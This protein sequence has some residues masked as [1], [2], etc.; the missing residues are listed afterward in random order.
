M[1]GIGG[2]CNNFSIKA[3]GIYR[4]TDGGLD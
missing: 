1:A 3:A 2:F 4:T